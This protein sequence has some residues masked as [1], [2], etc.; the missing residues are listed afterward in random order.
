MSKP[1]SRLGR[2]LGSLIPNG[3]EAAARP[4]VMEVPVEQIVPNPYQPRQSVDRAGVE[5]LAASIRAHGLIQPLIVTAQGGRYQLI[6]GERRWTAARLAG[7]ATV[8]V[9]VKE[10]TAQA[11]LELALVEN[12]QRAD[13]NVLEEAA[14]YQQLHE[15]FGLT[16]EQIAERVGKS[17]VAVTNTLRLLRLSEPV[18]A[19]ILDGRVSANH[20]RA[21][22]MLPPEAQP[23]A[24]ALVIEMELNARQTE[25]LV[26]KM[27]EAADAPPKSERHA[28]DAGDDGPQLLDRFREALRTKVDLVRGKNGGRLVI[29]FYSDEELQGLYDLLVR[30]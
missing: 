9:I 19:A 20:G 21:L 8:P 16:H 13:L 12:V 22:L 15:E 28:G 6:A 3:E 5:E 24:L 14:A 1:P 29:Y 25:A 18:R 2:G 17:R 27:L 4:T 11:M 23:D 30:E 26:R 10:A 7:M